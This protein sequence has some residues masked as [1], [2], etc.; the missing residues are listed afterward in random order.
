MA[1]RR[2]AIEVIQEFQE[3][4]AALGLPSLPACIVGPGYQVKDDVNVGVYS[5]TSL[6][7]NSYPYAGLAV[8][9]IVDL[10]DTPTDEADANAHKSVGVKLTD[11]FLVKEPALPATSLITGK[12]VTANLF[13]DASTGAFS[14]FDPDAADAPTF[15]VDIISAIGLDPADA[16]RKLVIRKNSDNELVVAAEWQSSLPLSNVV[17]RVLEFRASELYAESTFG[18][19]G[20]S[21]DVDSVDIDPGLTSVTDV[22]PMQVVEGTVL[23]S[24]RAL[25]PDLAGTLTAFTDLS[26]LEAVFGVGAVVPANVGAYAVNLALNNT[27][28]EVNFTGLSAAMFT[29]EEN[30]YQDALEYLE[31]K[32]VYAIAVMTQ[33]TAVH[34]ILK[35]HIEGMSL[36]TVGRERVGLLNRK[37]STLEVVV[38]ASG[39]GTE[40]TAGVSNGISGGTNTEFKDPTNGSFVT[41]AVGVGHFLEITDYNAVSGIHRSITPNELDYLTEGPDQIQLVNANFAITDIGRKILLRGASTNSNDMV[42]SI[43]ATPTAVLAT[44][45][46]TPS[47]EVLLSTTRAW[48]ADAQRSIAH[49][50]A[51]AVVAATNT[52]SFV[53]GAFTAADV[54]RLLFIANAAAAGNRGVF[55]IVEIVS[56][57]SIKT[58]EAPGANETFGLT[59]T[60][61]VYS[62]NREPARDVQSD[63]VNGTSR[64]WTIYGAAFTAADIGRQLSVAGAVNAGNNASHVIEAIISSTVARTNNTTIPVTETF[65]GLA[66]TLSTLDIVSMFP[67]TEEDAY[68]KGTRHEIASI[69]SESSLVLAAD[70]TAGFG[71]TLTD[72]VYRI[73][74][75]L[76]LNEQAELLAGY[77]T[78]LGS[79]RLV[80]T[81]P[82]VLAVSVNSVATKVPGYFAGA[83]AAG[84]TAGLPSQAGFTNLSLT[85]FVGREN[86]DDLFSD[87]QLDIIAGGGNM[88][89]TQPVAGAALGV[90]HQLTTDLSTIYFQEYSVTKNVDL[91]ARFFRTVYRPFLGIYNITD[92]LMDL[93]KTKGESGL[94]F[95]KSQ[96]VQRLGPP[97][98]TGELTRIEESLTQPDSVEID[99]DISV[100]LPL[101]NIKITLLV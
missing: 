86:S 87:A 21:K 75:D 47:A 71:G 58:V 73:T 79:R 91:V 80:S 1:Y 31:N 97:I 18:S 57:T 93:L 55:T 99:I 26:S 25:R 54:G 30:A 98:R 65:N 33:N 53:N 23:L 29:N 83:V 56:A 38:P 8:G 22:V 60:Q 20:I 81:W 32:D 96:R 3:A 28:T 68:I 78:S 10:T 27:T 52:W 101:N 89:L 51:D 40:T 48:I 63:S 43:S 34:Q 64:E 11:V 74:R 37:I 76:S 41:D 62:V 70:A 6:A 15:Y 9:A 100:P 42:Y 94:S 82:D 95:L 17:Y 12:L 46:P 13:Q 66:V 7:V 39:L 16:G 92:G 19:A 85:G 77:A 4:A 59:V 84:M 88:V 61:D 14:S 67:S 35:T 72:V 5:E 49:N 44:I 45:T 36:S 2:P 90:R 69:S 24:W 50:A